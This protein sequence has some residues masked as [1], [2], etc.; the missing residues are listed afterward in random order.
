MYFSIKCCKTSFCST[1]TL[2][3]ANDGLIDGPGSHTAE[4]QLIGS[5]FHLLLEALLALFSWYCTLTRLIFISRILSHACCRLSCEYLRLG[6]AWRRLHQ[7]LAEHVRLCQRSCISETQLPYTLLC[8]VDTVC[9]CVDL[10]LHASE[11]RLTHF[12]C[13]LVA[14][15]VDS[16]I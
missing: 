16:V 2:L 10:V 14:C 13:R 1:Q 5:C 6:R 12:Y 15:V 7:G 4:A 8:S 9:Y 3:A 11:I